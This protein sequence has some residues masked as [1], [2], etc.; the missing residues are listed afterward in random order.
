MSALN[1][2]I[3]PFAPG[4][5]PA[6]FVRGD[7]V[8]W[9]WGNGSRPDVMIV[10]N[11][12]ARPFRDRQNR[13]IWRVHLRNPLKRGSGATPYSDEPK[14]GALVRLGTVDEFPGFTAAQIAA[15][16]TVP[17]CGETAA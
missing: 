13:P 5:I 12:V 1:S 10:S 14:T 8:R 9:H 2:E 15:G 11:V 16:L 7:I 6:P 3:Y 17:A 4:A